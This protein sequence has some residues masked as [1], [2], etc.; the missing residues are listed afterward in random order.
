MHMKQS[1][2]GYLAKTKTKQKTLR[3]DMIV[4]TKVVGGL[5][6]QSKC[7][8]KFRVVGRS[9]YLYFVENV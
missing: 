8:I 7:A 9:I 5:Y 4:F 6:W 2:T 3:N 1:I